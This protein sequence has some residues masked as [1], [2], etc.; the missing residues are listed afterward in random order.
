MDL[1][2]SVYRQQTTGVSIKPLTELRSEELSYWLT[3]FVRGQEE[4]FTPNSLHHICNG[5]LGDKKPQ[6]LIIYLNGLYFAL[7][8]GKEHRQLRM[9]PCQIEL[10]FLRYTEDVSKNHEGE[11]IN[12]KRS[13]I[14]NH[15][16]NLSDPDRCFVHLFKKYV[17]FNGPHDAFYLHP[18]KT[19]TDTCWYSCKPLG[20]FTLSKTV[21]RLCKDA[22]VS[23]Y[24][25]NHS[26]GATAATRLYQSGV[27]L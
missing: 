12:V 5:V 24:K 25:T 21:A 6:T 11:K 9:T 4:K 15:H 2:D 13:K 17:K 7:H 16:A 10:V 22:G 18:T 23:G 14:I 26:L 8:S 20:H 3:R 27:A 19:P 1:L